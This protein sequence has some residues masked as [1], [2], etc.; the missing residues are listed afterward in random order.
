ME[1]WTVEVNTIHR[2]T[3]NEFLKNQ[4]FPKDILVNFLRYQTKDKVLHT[5]K[6]CKWK[7]LASVIHQKYTG[8]L[9]FK[10][11]LTP[12]LI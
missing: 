10:N 7:L 2:L 6:T 3:G 11:N 8:E 12:F 5:F 4:G 1:Y 9:N